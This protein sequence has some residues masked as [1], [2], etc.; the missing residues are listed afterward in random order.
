MWPL[1]ASIIPSSSVRLVRARGPLADC[2]RAT[3]DKRAFPTSRD[4][5]SELWK[6]RAAAGRAL[7]ITPTR[8]LRASQLCGH[9][10]ARQ[11]HHARPGLNG[12]LLG[13]PRPRCN[14][15][16]SLWRVCA[17]LRGRKSQNQQTR[18]LRFRCAA[19]TNAARE[20]VERLP[21]SA[22]RLRDPYFTAAT[23]SRRRGTGGKRRAPPRRHKTP[24][25]RR[26]AKRLKTQRAPW[27]AP[28]PWW[29]T[30]TLW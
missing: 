4:I 10:A 15:A 14:R 1:Q 28:S 2:Q 6:A 22:D 11:P 12:S 8:A 26:D 17:A 25:T 13:Y 19:H 27:S 21:A 16:G 29:A 30:A 7:E 18:G 9:F 24:S 23:S 3:T 20:H 5:M